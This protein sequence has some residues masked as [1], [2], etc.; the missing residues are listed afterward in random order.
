[1]PEQENKPQTATSARFLKSVLV[2][3][4]TLGVIL[5]G[6]VSMNLD[7]LRKP[8]M[9]ELSQITGLSIEIESLN[10]SLSN[11]LSLR[12][13]G[14]KVNSK[15][16][17]QQIFSAEEFFLN[18]E[19]EPLLKR[20]LKI[21]RILLVKPT[22]NVALESK[23]D[24]PVFPDTSKTSKA[25][26]QGIPLQPDEVESLGL[27]KTLKPDTNFIGSIRKLLKHQNL[28]L[29]TIEMKDATL[30]FIRAESNS[31]PTKK[32]PIL[33]SAR[34][35]LSSPSPNQFNID[36]KLFH[37][38]TEG[39]NFTGT[40]NAIDLLGEYIPVKATLESASLPITKINMLKKMLASLEVVPVTLES[41][42]VEKLF[43]H[44]HNINHFVLRWSSRSRTWAY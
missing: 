38:E 3:S 43:I 9:D 37:F 16:N 5:I 30:T 22:L 24:F 40:L 17:S 29:R 18:A 10:L 34:F 32:I 23:P 33:I 1:M 26:D 19:L 21:K 12:G 6:I 35:D 8:I 11:G 42:E 44:F 13:D 4:L 31:R 2:L 27:P 14:L 7:S 41:G 39:L 15:S 36:G 28:S 20:Q 25:P